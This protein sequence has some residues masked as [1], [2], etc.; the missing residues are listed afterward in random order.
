MVSVRAHTTYTDN[1]EPRTEHYCA[2]EQ[3]SHSTSVRD[4]PHQSSAGHIVINGLED[5]SFLRI[6]ELSFGLG[7]ASLHAGWTTDHVSLER[8]ADDGPQ[9]GNN[10]KGPIPYGLLN[11]TSL[12]HLDLSSNYFNSS[13]PNLLSRI[14]SLESL[15]F[16]YNSNLQG[17]IPTSLGRLCN[18][19]SFSISNTTLNQD[20]YETFHIFSECVL[21]GLKNLDMRRCQLFGQLPNEQLGQAKSLEVLDIGYNFISSYVP[22]SLGELSS[23]QRLYIGYNKLNGTISEIHFANL[24]RL[25]YFDASGNSVT[26][27]VNHDWVPP[28]QLVT[29][30]LRSCLIGPQFPSWLHSQ[31]KLAYLDI[32]D[33]RTKD[34]IPSW[35]WRSLSQFYFLNISH[36]Q[37]QG[38]ISNLTSDA[39]LEF[40]YLSSNNLSGPLPLITFPFVYTLDLSNNVLSG[41]IALF[42]CHKTTE[43]RGTRFLK[44]GSNSFSGELPNCWMN[45]QN[46]SVLELSDNNFTGN[47]PFS[48]G[49]LSGLQSLHLRNNGFFGVIPLSLKNC[50]ELVT[51]DI[52]E[53][54]FSG[55]IPTWIG[56]RFSKLVILNLQSNK[57]HGLLPREFCHLMSLQI[58]DLA[59]NNL[60]GLIPSCICNFSAMAAMNYSKGKSIQLRDGFYGNH[61]EDALL[62]MKAPNI[63]PFLIWL[64]ALIF[65]KINFREKFQ[66][67]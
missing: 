45:W 47:L 27:K 22:S 33:T 62:V 40:L 49:N 8:R 63:N 10:F 24:T 67:K 20:I 1:L 25:T 37:I 17:T 16:S 50:T 65:P 28:F 11:L 58:L 21:D 53:N 5:N 9:C 38:E 34:S 42:L 39:G 18:L 35:F 56:E 31:Q 43:P 14:R 29:L 4:H 15:D 13:I 7:M 23:L 57:F 66:W 52:G 48:I 3:H 46:L 30:T 44:L 41:S 19:K 32:S 60:S 59:Y 55:N 26:L 61:I 64:E 12:Q 51:L 6:R 36:N 2:T 54:E